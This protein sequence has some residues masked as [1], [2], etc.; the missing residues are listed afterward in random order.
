MI[1]PCFSASETT[2]SATSSTPSSAFSTPASFSFGPA[3]LAAAYPAR[4]VTA[5]SAAGTPNFTAVP[6]R[7][8]RL[9]MLSLA[10]SAREGHPPGGL[11]NVLHPIRQRVWHFAPP[12]RVSASPISDQQRRGLRPVLP[13]QRQRCQ[14]P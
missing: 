3:R 12:K 13:R 9:V 14:P 1:P 4:A 8:L 5:A 6:F 7:P 10:E 11:L 2:S